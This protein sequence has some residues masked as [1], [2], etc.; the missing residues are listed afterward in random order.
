[1]ESRLG[2]IEYVLPSAHNLVRSFYHPQKRIIMKYTTLFASLLAIAGLVACEKT[3]INHPADPAVVAVPVPVAVPGPA[4][5][6]GPQ[7]PQGASGD[8][9]TGATGATGAAGPEGAQGAQGTQGE[10]GKTGG[11]TVIVVPDQK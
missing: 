4:G 9:G 6:P 5:A 3:T 8:T 10:K 7:G 2:N 11:D 1:V